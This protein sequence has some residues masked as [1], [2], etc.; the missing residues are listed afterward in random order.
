MTISCSLFSGYHWETCSAEWNFQDK[1]RIF[2]REV[3]QKE[4]EK[5]SIVFY[6]TMN[7][8]EYLCTDYNQYTNV[9]LLWLVNVMYYYY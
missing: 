4:K 7:E 1:D 3:Y 8:R 9:Y 6:L 5:V 2:T